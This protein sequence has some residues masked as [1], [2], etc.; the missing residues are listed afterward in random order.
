MFAPPSWQKKFLEDNG[1]VE[2]FEGTGAEQ[3]F[4]RLDEIGIDDGVMHDVD[5]IAQLALASRF[6][7]LIL[8]SNLHNKNQ[9]AISNYKETNKETR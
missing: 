1:T 6:G 4:N 3:L 7:G 2:L 5:F 9:I 8:V